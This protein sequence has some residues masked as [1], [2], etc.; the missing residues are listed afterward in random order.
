MSCERVPVSHCEGVPVTVKVYQSVNVVTS[1]HIVHTNQSTKAL[2][3][4]P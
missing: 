4:C 3:K 2:F 1:L